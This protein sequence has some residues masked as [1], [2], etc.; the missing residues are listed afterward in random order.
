MNPNDPNRG[1][2]GGGT[3]PN[4][5]V[6]AADPNAPVAPVDESPVTP[7]AETPAPAE[8]TPTA[9]AEGT[10]EDQGGTGGGAPTG[11]VV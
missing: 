11:G 1:G 6:P 4:A 9:P 7:P 10:G 5:G 2:T 3:D 8:S